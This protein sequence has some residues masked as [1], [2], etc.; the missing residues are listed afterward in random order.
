MRD[1]WKEGSAPLQILKKLGYKI[2]VYSSAD[3][4]YFNMDQ[5]LF[6][7]QRKLLDHVEEFTSE[8]HLEPCDRD[9]LAIHSFE[10]DIDQHK[11]GT[12]YLFF[13]DSTHSE[14][15]FPKDF[16]L[17]FQPIS[18]EIS[19]LTINQSSQALE[20]LKNRYRNSIAYVDSL[21]GNFFST[22]KSKNLYKESIIAITGDH[23]EEFF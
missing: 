23:G 7:E 10:R 8:R 14:Y 17:K 1:Q 19:Y 13:L 2:R 12:V 15:S 22:L 5:I 6:G 11:E 16:P 9:A 20:Q 18:K 3:L 4:R 21:V